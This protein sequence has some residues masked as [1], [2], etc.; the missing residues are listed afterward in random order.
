MPRK[1]MFEIENSCFALHLRVPTDKIF[2]ALSGA[3]LASR[4]RT[5]E[6]VW[7]KFISLPKSKQCAL[8]EKILNKNNEKTT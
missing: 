2:V 4:K 6:S 7:R 5:K 8:S 1:S 3:Q